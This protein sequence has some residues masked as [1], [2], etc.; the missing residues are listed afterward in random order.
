MRRQRIGR[1]TLV[2][3]GGV[4]GSIVGLLAGAWLTER[5][6][7]HKAFDG[8]NPPWRMTWS[9]DYCISLIDPFVAES[10]ALELSAPP[11][12][13]IDPREAV[14]KLHPRAFAS[15]TS[16]TATVRFQLTDE[17]IVRNPRIVESS[18][19]ATLDEAI[20]SVATSFEFSPGS[21]ASGPVE[22]SMEYVIGFDNDRRSQLLR[23]LSAIGD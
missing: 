15:N 7:C 22:V 2:I 23:W 12:L 4:I 16:G 3:V 8:Q 14:R 1:T 17:G 13:L 21:A 19:N 6:A 18:G 10:N 5:S 9:P 20:A 11:R